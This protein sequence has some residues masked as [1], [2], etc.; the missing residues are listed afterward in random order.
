MLPGL[1]SAMGGFPTRSYVQAVAT[2]SGSGTVAISKPTG[3]VDGDIMVAVMFGGN[4]GTWTG[5]SGW[6]EIIDQ[7]ATPNLRAAYK[8]AS[9]EGASYTFT[10]SGSGAEIG[11]IATLR[12]LQYDTASASVTTLNG[13]GSLA[14]TGITAAGGVL[15]AAYAL[16]N[17]TSLA[18]STPSGMVPLVSE[19]PGSRAIFGFWQEVAAGATGTWASSITGTNPFNNGGILIALKPA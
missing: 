4:G 5:D 15:I 2:G 10:Y 12:G 11:F 14:I 3:T 16:F 17:G 18:A 1:A 19:S 9:G 7:G 8:V 6:T 13:D